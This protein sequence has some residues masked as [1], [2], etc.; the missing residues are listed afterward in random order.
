M[1]RKI[2]KSVVDAM[3]P[4]QL[5]WDSEIKGFGVRCQ[6]Q[7]KVYVLKARIQGKQRWF[8]I[9]THGSPWNPQKAR[10][11]ALIM[12]GAIVSG[13]KPSD[14]RQDKQEK[15]TVADLA[16]RF[17][18]DYAKIYKKAS[19]VA[20]DEANFKNHIVPLLGHRLVEEI[21]SQDI[22]KALR[23][24]ALGR[25][26]SKQTVNG[27]GNRGGALAKG[28][29][30]V[31]NRCRAL[32]S[33]MFN[34]AEKWKIIPLNSNPVRHT[35]KFKENPKERFLDAA[36]LER[37]GQVLSA[38]EA[39]NP[40]SIYQVAAIRLL[41]LTGA[42][43]GEILSLKWNMIDFERQMISL[44]DSKTGKKEIPLSKAAIALL[45]GLPKVADNEH[46]IVGRRDGQPMVNLRKP[47]TRLRDK[48]G[49]HDVRLHDLRHS[50]ASAAINAGHS[51]HLVGQLL[52]HKDTRTTQRYAHLANS[53]V[54]DA[55]N[56][57]ADS[58]AAQLSTSN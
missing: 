6:A 40:D 51:L 3:E 45:H 52:G 42:R 7:K 44:P 54:L 22:E 32:L 38:E 30:G 49:L 15:Q 53:V 36:E 35:S 28:G 25:T 19:S 4:S 27:R 18:T 2:T 1:K 58:I 34:L 23:D 26:A 11:E 31:S 47:W 41:L 12:L 46:V 10:E 24:I 21:T 9:G 16:N 8:T 48:A 5:I 39:D 56:K 37:L 20:G 57:T 13:A 14:L 43:L 33:K 50:F 55:G 29:K 17:L